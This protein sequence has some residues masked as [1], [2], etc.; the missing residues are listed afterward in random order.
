LVSG[1]ASSTLMTPLTIVSG[2]NTP[3][4]PPAPTP[5]TGPRHRHRAPRHGRSVKKPTPHS[6]PVHR[7]LPQGTTARKLSGR[8]RTLA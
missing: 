5:P 1:L 7:T 8:G 2:G 6:A 4:T 3:T